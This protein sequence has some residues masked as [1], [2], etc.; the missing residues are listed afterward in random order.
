MDRLFRSSWDAGGEDA[1][2]EPGPG[3]F[4]YSSTRKPFLPTQSEMR[5]ETI[6]WC[7]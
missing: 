4:G 7:P 5:W 3:D 1:Y 2:A 6:D